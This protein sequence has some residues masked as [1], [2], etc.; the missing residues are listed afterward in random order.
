MSLLFT[1]SVGPSC[2]LLLYNL[3]IID[4]LIDIGTIKPIQ[5]AININE[6]INFDLGK[7]L[8]L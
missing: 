1:L 4:Q 6:N 7:F 5:I 3:I 2:S 8:N